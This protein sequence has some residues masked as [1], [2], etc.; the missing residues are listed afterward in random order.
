MV[1]GLSAGFCGVRQS[2]TDGHSLLTMGPRAQAK[3]QQSEK[4]RLCAS[5]WEA[6]AADSPA[7]GL[8]MLPEAASGPTARPVLPPLPP[9]SCRGSPTLHTCPG[10]G[11]IGSSVFPRDPRSFM[12]LFVVGTGSAQKT[13]S[14]PP[15]PGEGG[16]SYLLGGHPNSPTALRP[17]PND[18]LISSAVTSLPTN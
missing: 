10:W 8:V 16:P 11:R 12:R 9:D 4:S 2:Q 6:E 18:S 17:H 14:S 15:E 5:E 7:Q 13:L 1:F 3:Q